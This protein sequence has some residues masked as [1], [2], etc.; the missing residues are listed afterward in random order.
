M[1]ALEYGLQ[2]VN[3]QW[4]M[5]FCTSNNTSYKI[6]FSLTMNQVLTTQATAFQEATAPTAAWITIFNGL[7][8]YATCST[9][10]TNIFV[11]AI[12]K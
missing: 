3:R 5:Y 10:S 7:D 9:S 1:M 2:Y 8:V 4:R 11:V 6:D 12:G